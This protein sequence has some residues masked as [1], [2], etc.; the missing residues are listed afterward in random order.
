MHPALAP[1]YAEGF[2]ASIVSLAMHRTAGALAN[3]DRLFQVNADFFTLSRSGT[4]VLVSSLSSWTGVTAETALRFCVVGGLGLL[5]WSCVTLARAW[6]GTSTALTLLGVL[7]VPVVGHSAFFFNDNIIS[8]GLSTAA[9]ALIQRRPHPMRCIASGLL[10]G[11]AIACRLDAILLGP[12]LL[13]LLL[14]RAPDVRR[15]LTDALLVATAALLPV[16]VIPASFGATMLD[17]FQV[18][19]RAVYLWDRPLSIVRIGSEALAAFGAPLLALTIFG[20]L[21]VVRLR[22]RFLLSLLVLL[23]GLY[24]VATAHT[25]WQSRQLLPLTPFIVTLAIMGGRALWRATDQWP[26]MRITVV[27]AIAVITFMPAGG[28]WLSEGPQVRYGLFWSPT[29]WRWWQSAAREDFRTINNIADRSTTGRTTVVL[30][31]TWD[32]DRYLHLALQQRGFDVIR[33]SAADSPCASVAE[34]F[35]R[36]GTQIVMLRLHQPFLASWRSLTALRFEAFARPCLAQERAHDVVYLTRQS[37]LE[38][39]LGSAQRAVLDS[40]DR[41]ART[42]PWRT[43][44]DAHVVVALDSSSLSALGRAYATDAAEYRRSSTDR[45]RDVSLRHAAALSQSTVRPR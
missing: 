41:A 31:D 25:I 23:P 36:E 32:G 13:L 14:H 4:I 37:R 18:S 11:F 26:R 22:I 33:A 27:T 44:Y 2:S 38:S 29:L 15:A 3:Y 12:S 6:S 24:V 28:T 35:A 7:V 1:I 40:V 34:R 20:V 21:H 17:A 42:G 43:G 19:Q 16:L 30:T 8:A 9:L 39:L 10:L 5:I 45:D